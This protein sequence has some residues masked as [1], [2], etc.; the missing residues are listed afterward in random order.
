[1]ILTNAN[2]FDGTDDP[3]HRE[4]TIRLTGNR[5]DAIGVTP[6]PDEPSMDVDGGWVLPGFIDA[7]VHLSLDGR[8]DPYEHAEMTVPEQTARAVQNAVAQLEAGF[9]T[10]RDCGSRANIDVALRDLIDEGVL[11]GPRVMAAGRPL[12][13]TGGHGTFLDPWE[14]DSAEE[15]IHAT[16]ANI[17]DGVDLVKVIAT[18]GVITEG[19][20][21]GAQAMRAAELEVVVD[22]AH[23]ADRPVAAHAH[24]ANG[25]EAAVDAGVDT[26]EHCTYA[27]DTSLDAMADADVGYVSTIISTVVQTTE[28]AVGD[29]IESYVR[30]KA[31]DAL[32]AQLETFEAAQSLTIPQ[33]I[34]TDAGT[35]R[36]PHGTGAKEFTQFV[37]HGFEPADALRAGT[38]TAAAVLD[39]DDDLGTIEP[40]KLADLVILDANPLEDIT[41]TEAPRHVIKDGTVVATG[42]DL[43]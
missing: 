13:I 11:L 17:R 28:A 37:D 23:R 27:T 20:N 5:I 29:G 40:G 14:C 12:G 41:Q 6:E 43:L 30:E 9:T 2:V 4:T 32:A 15:F 34:G 7:H 39:L 21:P 35:P 24:G 3:V 25:I 42:G 26:I 16:R 38:S 8:I 1:M 31:T 33:V 10:V 36:N 22:E 19:S 18:G